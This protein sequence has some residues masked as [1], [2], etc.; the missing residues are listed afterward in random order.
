MRHRGELVAPTPQQ[1][2]PVIK[3]IDAA[4]VIWDQVTSVPENDDAFLVD[5][6]KAERERLRDAFQ[7][8]LDQINCILNGLNQI[9]LNVLSERKQV[10]LF[11]EL[12]APSTHPVQKF[13]TGKTTEAVAS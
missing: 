4:L 13:R 11:N 3:S 9:E 2:D 5:V 10:K 12:G 8:V 7:V 1:I 6:E